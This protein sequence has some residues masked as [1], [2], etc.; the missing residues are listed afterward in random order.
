M[1]GKWRAD[2][3]LVRLSSVQ[4]PVPVPSVLKSQVSLRRPLPPDPRRGAPCRSGCHRSH[5]GAPALGRGAWWGKSQVQV[6]VFE[7]LS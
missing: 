6:P 2:G 1:A 4:V 3:E 5:G 7:A